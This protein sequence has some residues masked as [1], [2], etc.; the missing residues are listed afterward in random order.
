M[1]IANKTINGILHWLL[2]VAC[3]AIVAYATVTYA[4]AA[5]PQQHSYAPLTGKE[6]RLFSRTYNHLI[7]AYKEGDYATFAAFAETAVKEYKNIML[8]PSSKK[9]RGKYRELDALLQTL[10]TAKIMQKTISEMPKTTGGT[11]TYYDDLI[12]IFALYNSDSAYK[13]GHILNDMADSAIQNI[14]SLDDY[15]KI[16]KI[17]NISPERKE[18]ARKKAE[19]LLSDK[20]VE[21]SSGMDYDAIAQFMAAFPGVF[22]EDLEQLLDKAKTKNRM[23]IIRKPDFNAYDA[24]IAKFG[25][26]EYLTDKIKEYYRTQIMTK[27]SQKITDDLKMFESYFARFPEDDLPLFSQIE[28]RLYKNFETQR[29]IDAA[30]LYLKYFPSGRYAQVIRIIVSTNIGG[31]PNE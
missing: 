22:T 13:Y 28:E 6:K 29:T 10:K 19:R 9:L 7:A 3:S 17:R 1:V 2:L 14:T 27:P 18:N 20:F 30:A 5:E 31:L 21:L 4:T 12:D 15:Q 25:N 11:M 8:D 26:D 16:L 24:Y 23:S